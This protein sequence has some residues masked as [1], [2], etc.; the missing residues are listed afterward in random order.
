MVRR[1]RRFGSHR[2]L[3]RA[4]KSDETFPNADSA[5]DDPSFPPSTRASI[6]SSACDAESDDA[7]EPEVPRSSPRCPEVAGCITG[8]S[9]TLSG[10]LCYL[11]TRM[12]CAVGSAAV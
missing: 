5:G 4:S 2:Q 9:A 7:E 12:R 3:D 8:A 1:R 11:R 6:C 10:P